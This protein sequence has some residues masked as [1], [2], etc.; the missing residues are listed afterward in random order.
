MTHKRMMCLLLFLSLVAEILAVWG[1][2]S[3]GLFIGITQT[4]S[5]ILGALGILA[6]AGAWQTRSEIKRYGWK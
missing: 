3:D 2:F 5:I 6:F 1:Y 4:L